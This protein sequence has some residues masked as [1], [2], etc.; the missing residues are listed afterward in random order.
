MS[1]DATSFASRNPGKAVQDARGRKKKNPRDAPTDAE[2]A[3]QAINDAQKKL[4]KENFNID[5]DAFYSLRAQVTID[6]AEK[7]H[8]TPEYIKSLLINSSQFKAERAMTLRNAVMH[9][10]SSKA[11][12]DG[13]TILLP[14]LHRL[15]DEIILNGVDAEHRARLM[16]ALADSREHKRVG[17][18]ATNTAAATDV[19]AVV[20]RIRAELIKL[21]ERTGTRGLIFTTRGH[22]DDVS[23]PAFIESGNAAA[24]CIEVLKMSP[25]D[26]LRL[27]EQWACARGSEAIERDTRR[28]MSAQ[29]SKSAE[30]KLRFLTGNKT[31][32]VSYKN[33][34]VDMKE[35]WKVEIVGWPGDIPFV[36][37]SKI[38]KIELL[39]RIRDG[40]ANGTIGWVVMTP[41]QIGELAIDLAERRAKN[42]GVLKKRRTRSDT[43]ATHRKH[44]GKTGKSKAKGK[45]K[46]KATSSDDSEEEDDNDDNDDEWE[47]DNDADTT[48]PSLSTS[49]TSTSTPTTI[50]PSASASS[51]PSTSASAAT[52]VPM[53]PAP[54]DLISD[55]AASLANAGLPA[56]MFDDIPFFDLSDMPTLDLE[57]LAAGFGEYSDVQPSFFNPE[58]YIPFDTTLPFDNT[59]PR[60]RLPETPSTPVAG[61]IATPTTVPVPTPAATVPTPTPAAVPT[62]PAAHTGI[63]IPGLA[64]SSTSFIAYQAPSALGDASNTTSRKRKAAGDGKPTKSSKKQKVAANVAGGDAPTAKTRKPRKDKGSKRPLP[65]LARVAP[66]PLTAAERAERGQAL[67]AAQLPPTA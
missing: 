5:L 24:F 15:A 36:C 49:H 12:E 34:D 3:T 11:K 29:A 2:K 62:P 21:Y 39:R 67:L 55:V 6:L 41:E 32:T 18:R 14:D 19:R 20:A 38:K 31:L 7:Y 1:S 22:L 42:G 64:T 13:K 17:L 27:F 10:I 45:A 60:L 44:A 9:D 58:A 37:P 8:K 46:A 63:A 53:V 47:D 35:A 59:A 48:A 26:I 28:S 52:S 57:S 4:D 16:A 23:M 30:D 25:Y 50:P 51:L 61:P 54:L 43:G 56:D 40:W 65:A 33:F 66:R